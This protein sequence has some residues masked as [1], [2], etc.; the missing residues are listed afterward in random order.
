[1]SEQITNWANGMMVAVEQRRAEANSETVNGLSALLATLDARYTEIIHRYNAVQDG[2][3]QPNH[4][5][6]LPLLAGE[7]DGL[8][9]AIAGID[10]LLIANIAAVTPSY[11]D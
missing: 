11:G 9:A 8:R 5:N 1:M 7:M 4:P 10:A 6:E 2:E 3:A